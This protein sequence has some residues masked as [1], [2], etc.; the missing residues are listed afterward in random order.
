VKKLFFLL[1][2]LWGISTWASLSGS[3]LSS[4]QF[5]TVTTTSTQYLALNI[6]RAHLIVQ[7]NGSTNVLLKFGSAHSASEG[8]VI[9]PGGNYEPNIPPT[10][11]IFLKSASGSNSVVII[12]GVQQ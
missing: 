8:L 1:C 4:Q 7:N 3:V 6:S 2:L 11:A 10:A 12:E 9:I 5:Q